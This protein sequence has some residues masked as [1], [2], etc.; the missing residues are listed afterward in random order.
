MEARAYSSEGEALGEGVEL[1]GSVFDGVV[2]D[3][4]LHQV[5]TAIRAHRRQGTA[6]TKN[7][8]TVRGGKRKPWR[9]KG[10]GRARAGSIRSPLWRGG[11][12]A[13]GPHPRAYDVR[14]PRKMRRL[15]TRS[16]LNARALEG[17]LAVFEAPRLEAPRTRTVARLLAGVGA[18]DH[19]V[20]LLT[21]GIH[22]EL[23]LS[24][25]N[26]PNVEVR[27]WGEASAYDILRADLV[28]VESSALR[29][30]EESEGGDAGT[31]ATLAPPRGAETA[32]TGSEPEPEEER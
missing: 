30:A 5:V 14:V 32:A 3:A 8:R 6:S 18:D 22:R 2:N 25:R 26:L 16:A 4:A 10:T 13:F 29:G 1:P 17:D 23:L 11:A 15:A 27:P 12:V 19:R 7:R 21:D 28:L 24:A 20:L 9:Q 31:P